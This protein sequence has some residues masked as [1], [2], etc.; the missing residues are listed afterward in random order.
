METLLYK[1][2]RG[3]AGK[4]I[5]AACLVILPKVAI[6]LFMK[7]WPAAQTRRSSV[8]H[9]SVCLFFHKAK[10]SHF[11]LWAD[12]G[13]GMCQ[14]LWHL[15]RRLGLMGPFLVGK[16]GNFIVEVKMLYNFIQ[17][18]PSY[19][20]RGVIHCIVHANV[21][22]FQLL[23]ILFWKFGLFVVFFSLKTLLVF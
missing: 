15:E 18:A 14:R 2:E 16:H 11:N 21:R 12:G 9:P 6:I 5:I 19:T 4:I 23:C 1:L 13:H 7:M 3:E 8:Q 17:A 20:P 10:I 22:K